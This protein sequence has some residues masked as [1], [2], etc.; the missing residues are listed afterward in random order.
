[1]KRDSEWLT[2]TRTFVTG[3]T[4]DTDVGKLDWEGFISPLVMKQFALYMDHHRI[5]SDGSL[6]KGDNWQKGFPRNQIMKSLIRHMWDLWI[7]WRTRIPNEERFVEL[8]CAILFNVQA[9]L[10]ELI[11]ERDIEDIEAEDDR[12]KTA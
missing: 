1:M 6:R 3:A 10:L 8:L 9:M 11:L 2:R 5:Q 7:Q 12:S 4:R